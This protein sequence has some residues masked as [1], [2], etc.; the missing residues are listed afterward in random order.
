MRNI[1][2]IM[3]VLYLGDVVITPGAG[4]ILDRTGFLK[5]QV[6][7]VKGQNWAVPLGRFLVKGC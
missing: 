7:R 3:Y 2:H 6:W 5:L 4:C 1:C